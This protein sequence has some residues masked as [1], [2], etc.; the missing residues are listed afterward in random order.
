MASYV[1]VRGRLNKGDFMLDKKEKVIEC[2]LSSVVFCP[3]SQKEKDADGCLSC[4]FFK[5]INSRD[6]RLFIECLFK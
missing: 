4:K 6:G 3:E 2:Y 5:K 1:N